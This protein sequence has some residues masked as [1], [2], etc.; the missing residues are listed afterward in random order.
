[1][2]SKKSLVLLAAGGGI[3]LLLLAISIPAIRNTGNRQE[4][5]VSNSDTPV[6]TAKQDA[7]T[8]V[9]ALSDKVILHPLPVSSKS[10]T[11]EWTDADATDPKIIERIAH[12][13]D[14][15]VR[16][17]EENERIKRRQLV[18]RK[19]TA[20]AVVQ[21]SMASGEPVRTLALPGLDGQ[22]LEFAITCADLA[23]S[24]QSGTFTGLL[25]GKPR[26]LV[27]LAFKFGREAFS[28]SS[29][30]DNL[31][32]QGDP[33]EPGEIIVKSIDP[34]TYVPGKCGVSDNS[35]PHEH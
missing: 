29:P 9:S 7:P 6:T 33:R 11:H 4:T 24:G 8:P 34:A 35:E 16:M 1:M 30:E 12:N 32:L 20:A 26:S 17:A 25:A 23:P 14:E 19:D 3:A 28:V 2:T 27:T 18:Y 13:P 22:E 21:R 5:P 15:F 31:Y 10:A